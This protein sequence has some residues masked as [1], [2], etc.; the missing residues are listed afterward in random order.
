MDV[1][2]LQLVSDDNYVINEAMNL[3]GLKSQ[4]YIF[5]GF[6]LDSLLEVYREGLRRC[7]RKLRTEQGVE[8][9]WLS[10]N[11][12]Q[13]RQTILC[14]GTFKLLLQH[15]MKGVASRGRFHG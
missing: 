2:A 5:D 9:D 15:F 12:S 7:E 6:S 14:L 10:V 8:T 11:L 13:L 4:D 3:V 1:K